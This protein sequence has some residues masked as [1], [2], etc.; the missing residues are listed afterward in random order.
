MA[1]SVKNV[2][3]DFSNGE[4]VVDRHCIQYFLDTFVLSGPLGFLVAEIFSRYYAKDI[5]MHAYDNGNAAKAKR[6]N[7]AQ[8]MKVFR[9]IGLSDVTSEQETHWIA[10]LE[11][12]AAVTF[13]CRAYEVLTQRKL[14]IQVKQPTL[15][16]VAGYAQDNSL[17]KVRKAMQLNNFQEGYNVQTYSKVMVGVIDSHEVGLQEGRMLDPDRYSLP[18]RGSISNSGSQMDSLMSRDRK[19]A[20]MKDDL[21]QV[22]AKEIIV[23]QLDRNITHLRV[24]KELNKGTSSSRPGSP[25]GTLTPLLPSSEHKSLEEFVGAAPNATNHL[26]PGALLPENTLSLINS[27]IGRIINAESYSNW[28]SL[29]DPCT[30]FLSALSEFI[31]PHGD[32][33][34]DSLQPLDRLLADALGELQLSAVM[35]ADSC[36][37]TPK[38][39][40]KLSDLYCAVINETP[41]DAMTY[42]SAING[43]KTLGM[44]LVQKDPHS[45]LSLFVDFALLKLVHTLTHNANKRT[46]ILEL[47][48]SFSPPS[49]H[50]HVQCI[51]RLQTAVPD[52]SMF[53]S[54]LSILSTM[55]T[56]LDAVLVDLYSYYASIALG[57]CSPKV[58]A[59]AV[60]TLQSIASFDPA[61][62]AANIPTL[63]EL[64]D[65]DKCGG[66]VWWELQVNTIAFCGKFLKIQKDKEWNE[67]SLKERRP[68]GKSN[69]SS[70][71]KSENEQRIAEACISCEH[72]LFKLLDNNALSPMILLLSTVDLAGTVGYSDEFDRLYTDLLNRITDPAKLQFILG[73]DLP[74]PINEDLPTISLPIASSTGLPCIITP[75]IEMWNPHAIAS[76]VE[77]LAVDESTDQL[78]LFDLQ[79]LQSAVLSQVNYSSR[80]GSMSE[81]DYY[82]SL[83]S[84]WIGTFKNCKRFIFV[85]FCDPIRAGH[86]AAVVSLYLF[87]SELKESILSDPSFTNTFKLLYGTDSTFVANDQTLDCQSIFE[88]FLRGTFSAGSPY[89]AAVV[90]ALQQV[91]KTSPAV[92]ANSVTLQKMLKEFG[93]LLLKS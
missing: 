30:N 75:V 32:R 60:L 86:A 92:F 24:S 87:H 91:S 57:M 7:W 14:S 64:V 52:L 10:C 4:F 28:S 63:E 71:D 61:I 41:S 48:Y 88:Q 80:S 73:L 70:Q 53:V 34:P 31:D 21:P 51:R 33:S 67:G 54:C 23:K 69:Y 11:E 45:S 35:F 58:R 74:V 56:Q 16:K 66:V 81:D 65:P 2:R 78:S 93:T 84:H 5:Q 3:R 62:V 50:A 22:T 17:S 40:W 83:D 9:R 13:L 39:F 76:T 15:S 1:Y 36:A 90:H 68:E 49:A 27:C 82:F 20:N 19:L 25:E 12:G 6:D 42:F 89:N 46:G 29:N 59:G 55:E 18:Q 79:L 26:V 77:A 37:V 85:A 43:F 47:L 38:Q 72:I 44:F 8:L